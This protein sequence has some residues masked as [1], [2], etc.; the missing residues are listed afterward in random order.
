VSWIAVA[1]FFVGRR[2]STNDL[3]KN[4]RAIYDEGCFSHYAAYSWVEEFTG[5]SKLE[6]K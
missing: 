3:Y 4:A 1:G 5:H 2:H 6:N